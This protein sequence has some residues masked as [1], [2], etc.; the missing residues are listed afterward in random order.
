MCASDQAAGEITADNQWIDYVVGILAVQGHSRVKAPAHLFGWRRINW[1]EC[2]ILFHQTD[3][4]NHT[5]IINYGLFPGGI[6]SY[7][8]R[9]QGHHRW[10]VYASMADG[11]GHFPN[12]SMIDGKLVKPCKFRRHGNIYCLSTYI[13]TEVM[14]VEVWSTDA[15]CAMIMG[16][17]TTDAISYAFNCRTR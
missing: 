13:I 6:S 12:T 14:G 10:C 3:A 16:W 2:P 1:K 7:T 15:D 4:A 8:G 11:H 17:V 9:Q 5:S